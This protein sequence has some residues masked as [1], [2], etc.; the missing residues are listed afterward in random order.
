MTKPRPRTAYNARGIPVAMA[1]EPRWVNWEAVERDG[2]WTKV[3]LSP[4]GGAAKSND[5]S[6]WA[7]FAESAATGKGVGFMLGDGWLG[8]DLDGVIVDGQL[9]DEFLRDWVRDCG[10]YVEESPSGTGLHAIFRGVSRTPGTVNRRGNVEVYDQLRFF[11]ITGKTPLTERRDIG[12]R[13]DAVDAISRRFLSEPISGA[14]ATDK[15]GVR[16]TQD[17]SANDWWHCRKWAEMGLQPGDMAEHLRAKMRDEARDEKRER[18]DY[19][20]GTVQK[21]FRLYGR[22]PAKPVEI[23]GLGQAL[24]MFPERAPYV[25]EG[26]M[27]QGEVG[28]LVAAPKSRKSW[29]MADLAVCVAMGLSWFDRFE[30]VPGRVLMVDNEL[31]PG[32]LAARLRSVCQGHGFSPTKVAD[33]ID[34]V[35]LR[36]S[37]TPIDEIMRQLMDAEP[38]ALTIWD[39]LYMMLLD[40]MDENSNSD[41]SRLLRLFRRFATK[42]KAATLFVHHTAKG[43]GKDRKSIDAGAG[44]GVIGRAPDAH[45]TLIENEEFEDRYR[46]QFSLRSSMR[47][48]PF[49]VRWSDQLWR[50]EQTVGDEADVFCPVPKPKK[51]RKNP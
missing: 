39:A 12:S 25:I 14:Q 48:K 40:G 2:K 33:R 26:F 16:A 23:I 50:Y 18:A 7:T 51:Q 21:A 42:T 5:P 19:V 41:M 32:D 29:V 22:P 45:M 46:I 9:Q 27:R 49:D 43:G 10:T 15:G 13:Q 47:P 37:E 44:A 20:V 31:Q 6:T 30:C 11:C 36:E 3:P 28:A 4:R 35:T 17:A 38:Y 8:V 34:I 24:T 1:C